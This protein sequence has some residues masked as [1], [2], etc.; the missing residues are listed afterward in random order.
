MYLHFAC[1]VRGVRVCQSQVRPG[2]LEIKGCRTRR[3]VVESLLHLHFVVYEIIAHHAEPS[4]TVLHFANVY[5]TES[6]GA[7]E[8]VWGSGCPL[9]DCCGL[10]YVC[11]V[12]EVRRWLYW[13]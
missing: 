4:Y 10:C 6:G 1:P 5:H 13:I 12:C 11:C 9:C 8:R 7:D 3:K 2:H